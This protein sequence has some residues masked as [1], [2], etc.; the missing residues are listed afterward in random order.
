ME[1]IELGNINFGKVY[2][3]KTK[4]HLESDL[5]HDNETAYKIFKI[6]PK[7]QLAR[8]QRKI[9]LLHDGEALPNVVM[10][11]A[12]IF[13]EDFF[14]GYTM[15]YIKDS[16][17]LGDFTQRS[18]DINLFF[19]TLST[20]S[21]SVEQIHRDPRKIMIGDLNSNNIIIDKDFNPRFVDID[22]CQINGLRNETIPASLALYLK[23]RSINYIDTTK[24]SDKFSLLL[25]SLFVIF[26]KHVDKI[27]MSDFDEKAEKI[28]TLRNM[29]TLVLEI[30]RNQQLS[31]VPYV[32]EL[33]ASNDLQ[34]KK[35]LIKQ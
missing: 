17:N 5:Y 4:Y 25:C 10:P 34:L 20:I 7:K 12:E 16:I 18:K 27:S 9:E 19:Q 32:H 21:K 14:F 15:D 2:M 8:K 13:S 26:K 28:E 24:E 23:N 3:I 11:K 31:E 6:L 29:R 30:K 1:R 22:S 33:I 35:Q